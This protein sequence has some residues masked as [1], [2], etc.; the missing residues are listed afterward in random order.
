VI[1]RARRGE[2]ERTGLDRAL[3]ERGHRGDVV[4]TRRF[5][6]RAPLAHHVHP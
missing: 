2:A 3:R 1:E 5:T 4:R 6:V